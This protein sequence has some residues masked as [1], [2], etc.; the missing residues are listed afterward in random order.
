MEESERFNK[1]E[2]NVSVQQQQK[3]RGRALHTGLGGIR[4]ESL[5]HNAARAERGLASNANYAGEHGG[6]WLRTK[7]V[8]RKKVG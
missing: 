3:N 6:R 4:L 2:V 7:L 8:A 5:G 1:M